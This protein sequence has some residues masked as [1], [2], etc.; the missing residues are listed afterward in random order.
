MVLPCKAIS[1]LPSK[2]S[3]KKYDEEVALDDDR[4]FQTFKGTLVILDTRISDEGIYT[5]TAENELGSISKVVQVIVKQ[6]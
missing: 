4:I 6:G 2:I 3:W 1:E 5:C